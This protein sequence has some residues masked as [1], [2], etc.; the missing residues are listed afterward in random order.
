MHT[1]E[2]CIMHRN[3]CSSNDMMNICWARNDS[4]VMCAAKNIR[5]TQ[6]TEHTEHTAVHISNAMRWVYVF[7]NPG[8]SYLFYAEQNHMQV[9]MKP[10]GLL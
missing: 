6:P 8:K 9:I 4:A 3:I 10:R 5:H 7:S 2:T 1:C